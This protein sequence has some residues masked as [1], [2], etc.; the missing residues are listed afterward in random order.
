MSDGLTLKEI[1]L[2]NVID[3]E[4]Q[5]QRKIAETTGFSLGMT[6]ILLKKLVNKGYVKVVQ[7]NGR[8]LRYILTPQGFKEKIRRTHNYLQES[9]R[10]IRTFR[11]N[12]S[13]LLE[14]ELNLVDS[15]LVYGEGE[16]FEITCEILDENQIPYSAVD[17]DVFEDLEENKL[18]IDKKILV[19]C[20]LADG[21]E[22]AFESAGSK[23]KIL[24]V[25]SLMM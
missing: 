7:L 16:V 1:M 5:N 14:K 11:N 23:I 19:L 12:L 24:D 3:Q 22:V 18:T 6:N 4:D 20:C 17:K 9:V 13:L 25:V 15:I 10:R 21:C 8:T 2:I